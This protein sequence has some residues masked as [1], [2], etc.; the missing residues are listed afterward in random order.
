[1]TFL[2]RF[3]SRRF[4]ASLVCCVQEFKSELAKTKRS[5]HMAMTLFVKHAV[6]DYESWKRGYDAF[7]PVRK[8]KFGVVGASVHR[9]INDPNMIVVTH[10]FA[11][12]QAM[13]ALVNSDELREAMGNAGVISQ[14]ELW[15]ANDVEHTTY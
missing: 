15:L 12:A 3:R 7:G 4:D 8:E 5:T 13:M 2:S 14:P 6:K 11:D 9:D 1:M 10:R